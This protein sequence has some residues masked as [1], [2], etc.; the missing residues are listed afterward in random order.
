MLDYTGWHYSFF[1]GT[2]DWQH[3]LA[4]FEQFP[5]KNDSVEMFY[6]SHCFEHIPD[7]YHEHN[8]SELYRCL[9][10]GGVVRITTPDFDK[11]YEA[12]KNHLTDFF[13]GYI[14]NKGEDIYQ[15]FIAY[16]CSDFLKGRLKTSD[17]RRSLEEMTKKDFIKWGTIDVPEEWV[18]EQQGH[19]SIWYFE[20]FKKML[21]GA[22]FRNFELSTPGGSNF[23]EMRGSGFAWGF[24]NRFPEGSIFV[25][26][27]KPKPA[28]KTRKS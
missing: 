16:F 14:C 6:S 23:E 25:E 11:G 21:E 15:G 17:I 4:S 28:G 12:A 2:V 18:K 20:K 3:N 27:H 5:L 1:P 13:E 26:A 22:G 19:V 24:D 10:P 7:K 8:F 9:K